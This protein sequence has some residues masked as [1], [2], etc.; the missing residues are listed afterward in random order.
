MDERIRTTPNGDYQSLHDAAAQV[1]EAYNNPGLLLVACRSSR[2]CECLHCKVGA[3][4]L[5]LLT[6][7]ATVP[8][9]DPHEALIEI[10]RIRLADLAHQLVSAIDAALEMTH[11]GTPIT[12][13]FA[14]MLRHH[15]TDDL[16][17]AITMVRDHG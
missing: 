7:R 6:T 12:P 3:L 15:I 5:A 4:S 16:R 17:L 11:T 13:S 14:L 10:A 8:E 1:V 9:R 2:D